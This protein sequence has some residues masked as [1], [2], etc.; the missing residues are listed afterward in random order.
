M[1]RDVQFLNKCNNFAT[2][3]LYTPLFPSQFTVA[4]R[5]EVVGSGNCSEGYSANLAGDNLN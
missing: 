5:G 2:A 1:R 4:G 3:L